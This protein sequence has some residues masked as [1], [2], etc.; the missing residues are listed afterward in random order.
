MVESNSES[1]ICIKHL[2]FVPVL[3]TLGATLLRLIGE[4]QHWSPVF[5]RTSAGGAGAVIG[6]TWLPFIFGPYF[7]L[8]L[9]GAGDEPG[10]I[11]QA[12]GFT[13]L[14][15]V[16]LV[17]G[18]FLS[19]SPL[20]FTG[21]E[22]LGTLLIAISAL[23]PLLGWPRLGQTLLAYAYAARLPVAIV[24]FFA[25]SGNWGTHYDAL[26]PEYHGSMSFWP[27][28]FH[29]GILPQFVFWVA[30]T[31]IIGELFGSIAAALSRRGK[32]VTQHA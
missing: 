10:S 5:F 23:L 1:A 21:K 12:I 27:K 19:F 2:I 9:A 20:K 11:G 32:P 16:V 30:Y 25:I 14:S 3:I 26:P 18:A 24:M 13:V 6:I 8:K 22:A 15:L 17:L 28:Y 4:L 29:I 7:A 31:V